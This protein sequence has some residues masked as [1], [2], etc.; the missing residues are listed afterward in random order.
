MATRTLT[1][2]K[3]FAGLCP[4]LTTEEAAQL[5]ASISSDGCRDEIVVWA[6]HKDTILDGHHR[7]EI[8]ERL[9]KTFKTTALRFDSREECIEWIV[10]NQLGRRNLTEEQ[11]S[12]LRGKR[13]Q[14]EK[15][16]QGGDRASGQN[17]HLPK[18]A[19]KLAE[20]YDV[21]EKTIRRDEAFAEAVDTIAEVQGPEAKAAILAGES[22]GKAATVKAAKLPKAKMAKAVKTGELPK[23]TKPGQQTY[24]PEQFKTVYE[25]LGHALPKIGALNRV[26]PTKFY[27]Q[28]ENSIKDAMQAVDDW[29]KAVKP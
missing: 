9:G 18:T 26:H 24:N 2:D 13:Y 17:V 15:Q 7:Y 6:N 22:L 27:G 10:A 1:I 28:A 16:S 5:E 19:E 3:E 21:D 8:C 4:D 25:Y 20:E 11:K 29:K 12:Y 23:P 14:A